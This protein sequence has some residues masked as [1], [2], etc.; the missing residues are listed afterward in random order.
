MLQRLDKILVSQ[1]VGSRADAQRLIRR[2]RL[3]VDGD[4]CRDPARKV[5]PAAVCLAVDGRPL[6]YAE[7]LYVMLNKPAGCLCVSRDPRQ[8]TVLDL[9]P[10]EWR[11][12]GLFPAGRLDKDTVGFTLITDDGDLA[13]RMLSPRHHVVK[14]YRA[15]LDA[16]PTGEMIAAFANGLRLDGETRC[17]SAKC[18]ILSDDDPTM[19]EIRIAEGKYHQ[20]KRMCAAFDR[21][22]LW[23]QRTA[24]GG[25]KLDSTLKEGESRRLQ[26]A[27][28]A[29]I[30]EKRGENL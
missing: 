12:P 13:H 10:G 23:L 1:G 19:V 14:T 2:G 17:L 21:K 3:T 25:L 24:I 16:P 8:P 20:I 15:R 5:D 28:I 22:V 18:Q 6:A 27:E 9:L 30:W 26:E 4:V 29:R 11:R 7:H